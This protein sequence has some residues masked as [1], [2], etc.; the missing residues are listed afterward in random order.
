MAS[1]IIDL[2]YEATNNKG[3]TEKFIT[4]FS[5]VYTPIVIVIAILLVIVPLILGADMDKWID[6]A[7]FFL[8]ASCPCSLV[9]SIPLSFFS[10][11]G[12]ISKKGMIIKGTKHI[13]NLSKTDIIA[14][15]KTGTLTTGKMV[16]DKLEATKIP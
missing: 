12:A 1:Q 14:F 13:E 4:K 6:I 7:L 16:I 3:K 8:V 9:I 2:V 10:C 5:K 11:I 15:D